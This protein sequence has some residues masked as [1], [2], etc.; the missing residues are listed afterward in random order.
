MHPDL[1]AV[2]ADPGAAPHHR[3]T[4]AVIGAG[5][6]DGHDLARMLGEHVPDTLLASPVDG[7]WTF[8]AIRRDVITIL[9]RHTSGGHLI[10]TDCHTLTD[11]M[12]DSLLASL[13][14]PAG[15]WTIWL[16]TPVNVP[17]RPAVQSRL[18]AVVTITGVLTIDDGTLAEAFTRTCQQFGGKDWASVPANARHAAR[19][20][21]ITVARAA[22]DHYAHM[23][24]TDPGALARSRQWDAAARMLSANLGPTSVW[25]AAMNG[26][27]S[28]QHTLFV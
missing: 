24:V 23:S 6:D 15:A 13:E 22:S 2:T 4:I 3:H 10:V 28:R 16:L 17:F 18:Y 9:S 7:V 26:H 27:T 25:N 1:A 14:N 8:D 5:P 11:A 21:L 20:A 12:Q 19:A